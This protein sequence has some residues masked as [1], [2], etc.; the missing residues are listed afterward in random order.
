M[1]SEQGR[2]FPSSGKREVVGG[3]EAEAPVVSVATVSVPL[4]QAPSVGV[5]FCVAG[6]PSPTGRSHGP[7]AAAS[8]SLSLPLIPVHLC[9]SS[10]LCRLPGTW[11]PSAWV[12]S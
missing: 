5:T 8:S 9:H 2:R 11:R 6:V 12:L 3:R 4:M 1:T 7:A 10:L